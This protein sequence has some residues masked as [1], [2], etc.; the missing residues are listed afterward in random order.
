M[1]KD[2]YKSKVSMKLR[3]QAEKLLSEKSKGM[4]KMSDKDVK[5]LIHELQVHQIE[6]EM[7]NEEL[8]NA[9]IE[10]EESRSR[11]FDLYD[12]API[13]YFTFSQKGM[14]VE[15]NLTGA[16]LLG[17]ERSSL[18]NKPFSHFVLPESRN[19]FHSHFEKIFSTDTKQT[20]EL[21]LMKNGGTPFYASLQS[22]ILKDRE[23]NY[24]Q[25]LSAVSDVTDRNLS[26]RDELTG[27]YNRRGFFTLA[28]QQMKL[29]KRK[30]KGLLLV[31]ADL[32]GL[33]QINDTFG[34]KEGD[35]ALIETAN[36]LKET[37]RES[38]VIGRTGGDEFAVIVIEDSKDSADILAA[39]L[40]ENLKACNRKEN[41]R[42][43]LSISI[44]IV[45]CNPGYP[46]SIDELLAQADK[47]MYKQKRGKQNSKF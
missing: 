7:Q 46:C 34:H 39:R 31:V 13:G 2:E 43:S 32:D 4:Q 17:I 40:Q 11:Y 27:L 38:D 37:F 30:K 23:G 21:K 24:T 25:C 36:I 22:V 5:E 47:L 15:V 26:L 1:K 44:G 33:K 14:I 10:I 12:F 45:R 42:Y 29:A 9:R 16:K 19:L 20:C 41:R 28:Q 6:L 35:M 18:L 3:R 8:R